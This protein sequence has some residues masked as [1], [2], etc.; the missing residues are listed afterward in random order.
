MSIRYE[1]D[2]CGSVLKIKESLA[3]T[4]GKCP[5]CKKKFI[6]PDKG[7]D[8]GVGI[9][10]ASDSIIEKKASASSPQ[11][12]SSPKIV[13]AEE[14][15][16]PAN[17]DDFDLDAF[18]MDDQ[19]PGAKASAGLSSPP[20]TSSAP[21]PKFDKQ[22]R[23]TIAAPPPSPGS[24]AEMPTTGSAVNASAN[25]RDLLSKTMEDGRTKAAAMPG[26]PRKP[27]FN[28]DV[29]GSIRQLR[30]YLGYIMGGIVLVLALYWISDRMLT[31]RIDLPKLAAVSGTVTLDGQPLPNVVVHLTP[32]NPREGKSSSGKKMSLRDSTGITDS[33]GYYEIQYMGGVSGAPLGNARIWLEANNPADMKKI[34]G[35]YLTMGSTDIRDV[36]EAGNESKFNLDLKSK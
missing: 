2:G 28:F 20:I 16:K 26:A 19:A 3:G 24:S 30:S 7:A 9:E 33:N 15:P 1:C 18:L 17:G 13:A 8:S 4:S 14:K 29:A 22:G 32:V 5:T 21:P 23:R 34:P 35:K 31:S 25:A 36:K 6:V 27:L 11:P 12:A 10:S